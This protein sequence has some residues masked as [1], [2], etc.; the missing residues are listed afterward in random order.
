[1]SEAPGTKGWSD[2]L[3]GFLVELLAAQAHLGP[4]VGGL[5]HL[6]RRPGHRL[7]HPAQPSPARKP[8]SNPFHGGVIAPA[9]LSTRLSRLRPFKTPEKRA[10]GCFR[11]IFIQDWLL[12]RAMC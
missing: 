3:D 5:Q 7:T 12:W 2:W 8:V 11:S 1:M 9:H 4:A 10:R 6:A